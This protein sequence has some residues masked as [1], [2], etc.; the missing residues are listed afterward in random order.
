[1]LNRVFGRS[2]N[3]FSGERSFGKT[4]KDLISNIRRGNSEYAGKN[5]LAVRQCL[6]KISSVWNNGSLQDSREFF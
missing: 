6:G 4:F 1:M 5:L 2:S 3:I